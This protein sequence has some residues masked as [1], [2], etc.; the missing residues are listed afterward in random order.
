MP[1]Y[2]GPTA[3]ELALRKCK[4]KEFVQMWAD[5]VPLEIYQILLDGDDFEFCERFRYE[6]AMLAKR[7]AETEHAD[8]VRAWELSLNAPANLGDAD[9]EDAA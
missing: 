3:I 4:D 1:E 8:N 2:E 7:E 5:T 6:I 9:L